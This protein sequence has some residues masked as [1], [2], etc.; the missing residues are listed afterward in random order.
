MRISRPLFNRSV[1]GGWNAWLQEM[2]VWDRGTNR[3]FFGLST[4]GKN[5]DIVTTGDV[6]TID[7]AKPPIISRSYLEA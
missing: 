4:A 6:S 5:G 7:L 1:G 2:Q 3:D